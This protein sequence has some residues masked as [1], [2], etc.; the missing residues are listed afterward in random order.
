MCKPVSLIHI[1]DPDSARRA[2]IGF[3]LAGECPSQI[4]EDVEEFISW[5]PTNGLLL[6]SEAGDGKDNLNTIIENFMDRGTFLP[7]AM[8]SEQ[9]STLNVVKA[10]LAGAIDYLEWPFANDRLMAT[11]SRVNED[12]A[13]KMRDLKR[14]RR[15]SCCHPPVDGS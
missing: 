12:A 13:R 1:V 5:R 15:R 9:P 14:Q 6:L 11:M 7:I 8:Y 4:Y 3:Q 10:M 2:Q